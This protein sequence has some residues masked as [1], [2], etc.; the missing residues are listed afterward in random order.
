MKLFLQKSITALRRTVDRH[1]YLGNCSQKE[2]EF[3]L[4]NVINYAIPHFYII[5]EI[6]KNP[7]VGRPIVAGYKWIFTP[8]SI[9]AGHFL[10]EFYSKFDS[11]LNDSLSLVKL[12]ESLR[13]D[14][15]CFLFTIDFKSLYTNIPVDDAINCIRKLCF[16]YQNVIPNAHFIIELLDLV[17]NSSLMVFDGEYFQQIFGLIMGT[18]VAPILTNIYMAMLEKELQ[19]KCNSDPK[20]IWPVLF[21][22]FIDDGFGITLGLRN[23]VIYWIE[24]F[25]EL[26]ESIKIDK[27]TWGNALDYMDMFIYKRKKFYEDGKLSVSIHQKETNKFMYIPY[28][29]FH[30]RHTIKNYVWGELRRYV[31]YNT[32]EKNF[33]KLRVRFFLRL[34]NRG[35]RKYMLSKLFSKITYTQ[36]DELLKIDTSLSYAPNSVTLQEAERRMILDGEKALAASEE[37]REAEAFPA[38]TVHLAHNNSINNRNISS[39]TNPGNTAG[40]SRHSRVLSNEG[41][42]LVFSPPWLCIYQKTL[43]NYICLR[44][45]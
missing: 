17:L 28:R 34:R 32:E 5:W 3:L 11:I 19:Q 10:K 8:A 25:N 26:R 35:F 31:R 40:I 7:I 37:D 41:W 4:S 6:L 1:F 39:N 12:L 44:I 33:K 29:S 16:E 9:F 27:Y 2:K 18:N 42:N 21:K 24:K 45:F 43:V 23:D 14:K 15:N 20:L 22:R 30:Q 36:R 13:F 38:R